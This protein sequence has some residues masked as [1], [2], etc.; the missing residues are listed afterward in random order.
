MP[1]ADLASL[2][3]PMHRAPTL[4]CLLVAS[5]CATRT[6]LDTPV[7]FV[8]SGRVVTDDRQAVAAARV[9]LSEEHSR[10]F[11]LVIAPS[12]PLGRAMTAS[13]G[14]FRIRVT[15]PLQNERLMLSVDG[16]TYVLRG[17]ELHNKHKRKND[18]MYTNRVRVPGPNILR[19]RRGFVPGRGLSSDTVFVERLPKF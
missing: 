8:V 5:G 3:L 11:P 7:P 9:S 19:V 14:S 6:P 4:L 10:L 15:T 16:R 2:D 13:D 1:A 17:A 18:S 12:R